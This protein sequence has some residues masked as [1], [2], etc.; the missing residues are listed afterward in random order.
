MRTF[1]LPATSKSAISEIELDLLLEAVRRAIAANRPAPM[2][3]PPKAANDD[4]PA[5]PF[6]PFPK[7]W[8]AVS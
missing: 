1:R 3:Q 5:W 7:G 8:N 2:P 6:I 4:Q